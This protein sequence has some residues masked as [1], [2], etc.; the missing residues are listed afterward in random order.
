M[1]KTVNSNKKLAPRTRAHQQTAVP[2]SLKWVVFA[3]LGFAFLLL[4]GRL[5]TAQ[6]TLTSPQLMQKTPDH[7]QAK[8]SSAFSPFESLALSLPLMGLNGHQRRATLP[9]TDCLFSAF[10]RSDWY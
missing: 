4:V 3:A 7:H 6:P 9:E 2:D 10:I 1:I 5:G 8:L